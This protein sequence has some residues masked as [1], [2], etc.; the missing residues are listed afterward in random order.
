MLRLIANGNEYPILIRMNE[1]VGMRLSENSRISTQR[2]T[3]YSSF[4]GSQVGLRATTVVA[5]IR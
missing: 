2:L 5:D 1:I 4:H 3:L